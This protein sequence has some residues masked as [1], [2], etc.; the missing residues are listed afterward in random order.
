VSTLSARNAQVGSIVEWAEFYAHELQW[1]VFPTRP[2]Q[3]FGFTGW[4][5]HSTKDAGKVRELWA[6]YPGAGIGLNCGDSFVFV[7][8]VDCKEG[9]LGWDSLDRLERDRG[10]LPRGFRSQTANDGLHIILP[11]PLGRCGNSTSKIAPGIDT[12]GVGG[13][14]ILPP[15]FVW[16]DKDDHSKGQGTYRWLP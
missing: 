4:Q 1:S 16:K 3:K 12:R 7:I 11:D 5:Q 8:D 9:A 15:T 14:I 13:L 6:Q 10:P 2:L